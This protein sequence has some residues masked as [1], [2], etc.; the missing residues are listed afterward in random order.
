[1]HPGLIPG[2]DSLLAAD[3]RLVTSLTHSR[4]RE[5]DREAERDQVLCFYYKGTNP[6]I[7]ACVVKNLPAGAGY[8]C[9]IPEPGRSPGEGHGNPLQYSCLENPMD[10]GTWQAPI[11]GGHKEL[12]TTERTI[13][14]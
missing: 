6:L 5:G 1:M 13:P 8:L 4:G 2:E 3:D 9:S 12:D 10:R 7:M 14:S 11:H